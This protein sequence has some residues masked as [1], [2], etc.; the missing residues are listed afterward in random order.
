MSAKYVLYD[1]LTSRVVPYPRLDDEPVVGLDSSRYQV[2]EVVHEDEPTYDPATQTINRVSNIYLDR[3]Q[4]VYAYEVIDI[5][6][7]ETPPEVPPLPDYQGFYFGF[8]SSTLYQ[9]ILI[10]ALA[11]PGNDVLGNFL[12]IVAVALQDAMNGRVPLPLPIPDNL[13]PNSLQSAIWLLMNV[14]GPLLSTENLTEL[15]DLLDTHNL[16]LYYT[17]TPP[18][19]E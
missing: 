2:L 18:G 14:L 3:S 9:T 16:S 5:L 12:T 7:E 10:P 8:M 15:Q 19:G 4:Y 1:S 13:T 17:L 6:P 11:T